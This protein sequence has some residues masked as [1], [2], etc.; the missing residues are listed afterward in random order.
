MSKFLNR[1]LALEVDEQNEVFD[2][3]T[4]IYETELENAIAAGTLDTGMENVKADKV[5]IVDDK[6]IN[7]QKG[8]GAET[9]YIQAKV[10]TRP[11]IIRTVAEASEIRQ[12]GFVGFYKTKS[13]DVRSVY[14]MPDKTDIYGKINKQ[15]R[16]YSPTGK[17]STWKESTLESSAEQIAKKDWQRE[18]DAEIKKSPEFNEETVHM[19]TGALLPV[20]NKLPSD[21]I[22]KVKR[23]LADDGTA[24]LGRIIGADKI[25][26]VLSLFS[27]SRTHEA[28]TGE[29]RS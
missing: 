18:W 5:E 16:L 8:T 22:T 14:R 24:Y 15:Y 7:T 13:G 25:D 2:A 23:I 12:A 10:Y 17:Y 29:I 1:I 9:H 20:W 3:F 26:G 27:A 11:K 6:V 21:G 4:G 28:Y 19:L